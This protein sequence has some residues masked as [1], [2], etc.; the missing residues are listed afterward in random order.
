[1][2]FE[3]F[4]CMF[5][6]DMVFLLPTIIIVTDNLMYYCKNFAIEFH[7]LFWHLRWLWMEREDKE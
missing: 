4:E 1:M 7:F 3:R 2:K 5:W 6:R